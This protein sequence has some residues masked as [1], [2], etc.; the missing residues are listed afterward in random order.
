MAAKAS[1]AA[2]GE[3]LLELGSLKV[4]D[5]EAKLATLHIEI[6][7]T[8]EGTILARIDSLPAR[9]RSMTENWHEAR[10]MHGFLDALE[11]HL[12]SAPSGALSKWLDWARDYAEE[13]DPFSPENMADLEHHAA[14]L[15][16]PKRGK[17]DPE[18]QE[19]RDLRI[20]DDYL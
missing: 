15:A 3:A 20:L 14:I 18:E 17:P 5:G 6:P 16:K 8:V 2:F 11:A 12:A 1:R 13:L 4:E 10:R 19:L 9:L 7:D